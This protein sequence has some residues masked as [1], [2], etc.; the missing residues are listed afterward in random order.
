VLKKRP[1]FVLLSSIILSYAL[2]FLL[3]NG[4]VCLLAVLFLISAAILVF[5]QRTR[6]L[7]GLLF[8]PCALAMLNFLLFYHV[9]YQPITRFEG[10]K[11][12]VQGEI[13]DELAT[14]NLGNCYVIRPDY[15]FFEEEV[16]EPLGDVL[17]YTD[18]NIT[19]FVIGS[20][21]SCFGNSFKNES[22]DYSVDYRITQRRFLS[23]Y[24]TKGKVLNASDSININAMT[25]IAREK[26][27][28]IYDD[29]F[30][31][32]V[33]ALINGI[34]LG[35][36]HEIDDSIYRNFKESGISHALSVSG[37]HLAFVSAIL[38]LIL[39][40]FGKNLYLRSFI[41][42][43][44]IWGFTALTGFPPSCCR[45]AIMLTV[46][47]VG[48]FLHRESDPLT[49]LSFAVFV[50]CLRNPFAVMNPSLLLSAT[51]TLGILL[52]T[53][54][55]A[56]LFP[57]FKIGSRALGKV[58]L[59]V[60]NTIAMSVAA[61]IG[62]L[63]AMIWMFNSVSL[64]APIT[65]LL[66][67]LVI[68]V[69]FFIGLS[70][71]I[72]GWIQPLGFV[73]SWIAEVLYNYCDFVTSLVSKLPFCTV[74]TDGT[75]FWIVSAVICVIAI[76]CWYLFYQKRKGL[77][78]I[79]YLIMAV[80]L[81]GGSYFS[82]Y[83]YRDHLWVD[84]VDVG[85]GNTVVV[86]RGHKAV[87]FDCGGSGLGYQEISRC[88]SRRGIREISSI[89]LTHLDLD[90]TKYLEKLLSSYS[91]EELYL[92]YRKE[93]DESDEFV[94]SLAN[95]RSTIVRRVDRDHTY[96]LNGLQLK[97]LTKH[98]DQA[99]KDENQKSLVYRLSYGSTDILLT[100]DLE[101]DGE[102][103]FVQ[104][105]ADEIN[106]D[107]LMVPHH[108]SSG[109]AGTDLLNKVDATVAVISVGKENY[110]GLPAPDTLRRI[111]KFTPIIKRT[112]LDGTVSIVITPKDYVIEGMK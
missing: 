75:T 55:I 71:I 84:F 17:V 51:A 66:L 100:G 10:K 26:I 110:Y 12:E 63:P 20:R 64:L 67:A 106:S 38:W 45:A 94:F 89:Y 79:S 31:K 59:F 9:A 44:F 16:Y 4:M 50:C 99:V 61:T 88:L 5:F 105:Y 39:S 7:S 6:A 40:L 77:L 69:L 90:H 48:I 8:L 108:G 58:Y 43:I 101:L 74:S 56:A 41:Q 52:L 92:P 70:A 46:F 1:M 37:M 78:A 104:K 27:T 81:I 21:V 73:I 93:Y 62:T 23:M 32:D 22:D 42:I 72:F 80:C 112:D 83:L 3:P 53:N 30:S 35:Q 86:S 109:G 60:K 25:A 19:D 68:E 47:Q 13:I 14:R 54:K 18:E 76:G 98:I 49:A 33:S 87:L 102:R 107:I 57:T 36:T 111:R 91:V 95:S 103:R 97:I 29:V 96:D 2:A 15:L 82:D 85:Q 34:T 28:G 11:I 65:N 24:A